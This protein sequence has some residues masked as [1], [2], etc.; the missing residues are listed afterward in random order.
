M[1]VSYGFYSALY[2]NSEYDRIYESGQMSKLFDGLILDGVYLSSREDDTTNQ[3]FMVSADTNN[4]NI[5]IA[6]GKAWFLGTYTVSDSDLTLTI[7]TA[8]STYDRIDAVVIEVNTQYTTGIYDD[9]NNPT[10]R[11]NSIKIVKGTPA[12][13]PTKPEMVHAN[14]IDQFPIA[15]ITVR[16][17]TT[18]IKSYDIEYVVGI[19]TPYF[20]W[21][22]ERLS[23]AELYSKWEPA[24]GN[25]TMPFMSW[26]ASMQRMLVPNE[27]P[28]DTMLEELDTINENDYVNGSYPKV[29][30]Q[31][32]KFNGDGSTVDF[33][34][35]TTDTIKSVA[36]VF[37]DG[38]MIYG[39]TYDSDTN[40]VT[41]K[42]APAVGTNNVEIYYVVDAEIYTL[43]F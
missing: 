36:D 37:V 18:A 11:F 34:I 16:E 19:E 12:Q 30:E 10:E 40:T 9:P 27:D 7:D 15:Y 23:I 3:Q 31:V 28:Y 13:T 38:V 43:Y 25:I 21:L 5:K 6:P 41:L 33:T 29:D 14:G 17:N 2:S 42:T 4:M 22:G 32:V 35:E 8:N 24:L 26:F 39:Y 1:A 20:A